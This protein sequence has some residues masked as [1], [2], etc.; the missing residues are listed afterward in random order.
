VSF[1]KRIRADLARR[2]RREVPL[3]QPS[4]PPSE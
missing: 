2:L 3:A 4:T 1:N